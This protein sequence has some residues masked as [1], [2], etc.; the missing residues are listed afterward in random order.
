MNRRQRI[1]IR[2]KVEQLSELFDWS[3]L[4]QHYNEAHE[5]A[6]SRTTPRVGQIDVRV[7]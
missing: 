7:V 5:M 4:V 6:M 3:M 1:E 2:N